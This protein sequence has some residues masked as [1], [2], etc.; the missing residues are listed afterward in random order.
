VTVDDDPASDM[1]E[2]YGRSLFFS[3]DEIEPLGDAS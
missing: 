2:W 1:H 3:P